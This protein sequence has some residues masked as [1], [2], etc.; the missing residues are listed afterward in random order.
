[1]QTKF[2]IQNDRLKQY[3]RD[4][5]SLMNIVTDSNGFANLGWLAAG[6][7]KDF[8]EAQAILV[9]RVTD[10]LEVQTGATVL[11]I[12]CGMGAPARATAQRL[13][14]EVVGLELLSD[15]IRAGN[16][17]K[18]TELGEARFVQGDAC[19]LPFSDEIF[20]GVYSIESAFHYPDKSRFVQ[21]A[22]RVLK[23]NGILAVADIVLAENYRGNW[24]KA[25][26]RR[27]LAAPELFTLSAYHHA[28]TE[29]GLIPLFVDNLGSGV[30][31]SIQQ[32]V[33]RVISSRKKLQTAGYARW[34]LLTIYLFAVSFV[35]IHNVVPVKYLLFVFQKKDYHSARTKT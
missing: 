13:N 7:R 27:A 5:R 25:L 24:M 17:S 11:E 16:H 35:Y 20:D 2:E 29:T 28:A 22:A 3:Y 19:K 15:Q 31:R 34:Y 1:M 6:K 14:I 26:C 30:A 18:V 10:T 33:P 32:L 23:P 12:G 4:L 9:Q 8:I 21:E